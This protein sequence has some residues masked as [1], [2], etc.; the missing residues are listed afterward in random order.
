MSEEEQSILTD[1]IRSWIGKEGPTLTAEVTE[2]EIRQYATAVGIGS[3]D[4]LFTD[5]SYASTTPYGAVVAPFLF[6]NVP[7]GGLSHVSTLKE[8]GIP[9]SSLSGAPRPPIPLPRTMAGGT[10]IEY[11]R[12][13]RPGDVLM[14]RSRIA[15][16]AERRGSSGPLVFTTTET[17]YSDAQDEVVLIVRSTT[18]SR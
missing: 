17:I 2:R 18:I 3:P 14:Q 1:E 15:N 5:G 13:I 16:I 4:P 10:E 8:D 11:R 6:Y 12:P 9:A 7:F